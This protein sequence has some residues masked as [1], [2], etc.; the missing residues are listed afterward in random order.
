M[1]KPIVLAITGMPASGK[2]T[3]A[4]A[5][6]KKK[7][8]ERIKLSDYIWGWLK[9]Q[10]IKKTSVTGAMFGLYLHTVYN[11]TPIIKW[12]K[13][14]VKARKGAKVILLD[15]V[16][17]MEE[18]LKFRKKY[19][20]RFRLIAVVASPPLRKAREIKRARFGQNITEKSFEMR[21]AE[22]LKIGIGSVIALAD[23]YIDANQSKKAMLAEMEQVYK[24][25]VK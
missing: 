22:E 15:S 25:L 18:Y 5:I 20:S 17:T 24:A 3:C 7:N 6:S 4:D 19:N 23:E 8:V 11:D 1:T 21:D 9:E 16:R 2:S 13:K 10:G 14:Q 12:T